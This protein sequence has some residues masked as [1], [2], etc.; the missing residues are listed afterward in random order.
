MK[1]DNTAP[2][3]EGWSDVVSTNNYIFA[4]N[5]FTTNYQDVEGDLPNSVKI[6]ENIITPI[7]TLQFKGYPVLAP[8]ALNISEVTDL[9]FNISDRFV[10]E[11][12]DIYSFDKSITIIID[13]HIALG[14]S[15]VSNAKGVMLFERIVDN[16][17]ENKY[18]VGNTLETKEYC[19]DFS[20]SD[21]NE[22]PL[23]SNIANVCLSLPD[24][25]TEVAVEFNLPPT[26]GDNT[27]DL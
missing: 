26:V 15:L 14:Y 17:L 19:F 13:D 8:F 10:F 2:T 23:F 18:V 7:G 27:I 11:G 1:N 24:T 21:D 20:V 25:D 5:M 16:K 12:S 6:L 9:K 4:Q 3:V 22:I